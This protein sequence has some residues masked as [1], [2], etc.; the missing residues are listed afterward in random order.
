MSKFKVGDWVTEQGVLKQI[1]NPIK[2][3]YLEH[4]LALYERR[5]EPWQPKEGEYIIAT[6]GIKVYLV[7]FLG[8]NYEKFICAHLDGFSEAFTKIQ[9]FR[10]ELPSWLKETNE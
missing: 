1:P 10:G 5:C 9:P 8:M 6:D 2:P 7:R 4:H 3:E